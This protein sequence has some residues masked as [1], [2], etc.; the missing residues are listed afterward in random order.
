MIHIYVSISISIYK[1]YMLVYVSGEIIL[2]FHVIHAIMFIRTCDNDVQ[3]MCRVRYVQCTTN[4]D[5]EYTRTHTCTHTHLC[6]PL[7]T[8]WTCYTGEGV[9]CVVV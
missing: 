8:L 3:Y 5:A 6:T 1:Y 9:L 4:T 7:V 2:P